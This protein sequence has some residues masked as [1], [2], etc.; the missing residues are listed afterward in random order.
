MLDFTKPLRVV[1]THEPVPVEYKIKLTVSTMY[2]HV[3]KY[4]DTVD[5]VDDDGFNGQYIQLENTPQETKHI[6]YTAETF[7]RNAAKLR[8]RGWPKYNW[9]SISF[10]SGHRII[11]TLDTIF[12]KD[13]LIGEWIIMDTNGNDLPPGTLEVQT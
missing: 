3:I 7:P 2:P 13:I 4:G 6:A 5:R 9:L 12:Y 11:T 8:R 1:G 10:L